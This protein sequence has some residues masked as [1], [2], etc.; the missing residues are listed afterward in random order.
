MT[1]GRVHTVSSKKRGK[2]KYVIFNIL[3]VPNYRW[4][5][6]SKYLIFSMHIDTIFIYI[7]KIMNLDLPKTTSTFWN[8]GVVDS[9]GYFLLG[10]LHREALRLAHKFFIS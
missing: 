10:L 6:K 7:T 8:K 1:H 4:F 5:S 9:A 3:I 2:N